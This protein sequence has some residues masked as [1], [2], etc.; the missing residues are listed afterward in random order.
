MSADSRRF[1]QRL[2]G[3]TTLI[4]DLWPLARTGHRLL[5]GAAWRE[6]VVDNHR[7]VWLER[8]RPSSR[9]PTVLLIHGFAAMKE[10]WAGWLPL[11][12]RDWHL[13]AIDLPGF[14]ESDYRLGAHYTYEAQA[15][16]LAHWL[17][18]RGLDN[19]HV[20]GSS[21]GG[22]I[23]TVLAGVAGPAISSLTL[24]NSAGFPSS[25]GQELRPSD[26]GHER[27]TLIPEDLPGIYTMFNSVG[28]GRPTL[29]GVLM[30]GLLGPDLL[31]RKGQHKHIFSD[32][33]ADP[34]A[35]L[36]HLRD[37]ERPLLVQW[38][39]RDVVTPTACVDWFRQHT[40]SAQITVFRRVGHLPMME[41]PLHSAQVLTDFIRRVP[42]AG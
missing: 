20:V 27:T 2:P 26:F 28:T 34:W 33:L 7:M 37:G 14:G 19:V 5:Q 10:N 4:P 41:T 36:R 11:L 8:G 25:P 39:D 38:G 35:P 29:A 40:P 16:R 24:L 32:M 18:S 1:S 31:K 9:R 17:Q 13:L 23:A 22:A 15:A 30:T 6:A 42:A 21:M 3:S 12:P